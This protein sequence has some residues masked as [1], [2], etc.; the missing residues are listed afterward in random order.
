[1]ALQDKFKTY[2]ASAWERKDA[3]MENDGFQVS[4]KWRRHLLCILDTNRFFFSVYLVVCVL[5]RIKL[6]MMPKDSS[7]FVI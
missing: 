4:I 6:A 5:H 1:M 2:V 7:I 3:K